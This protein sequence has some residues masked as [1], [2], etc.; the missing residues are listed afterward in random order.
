MCS[1]A[2]VGGGCRAASSVAVLLL[3]TSTLR[4]A[5]VSPANI[6]VA[7]YIYDPWTPEPAVFGEHG[8][9]FTEWELV[10][11]GARRPP[12]VLLNCV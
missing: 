9:N 8:D 1:H 5:A 11:R 12:R 10:R 3:M 4:V 7:A 6:T 2:G